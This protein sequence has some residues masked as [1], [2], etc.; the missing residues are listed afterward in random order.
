M[1]CDLLGNCVV[2]DPC[3]K[4][5]R[6]SSCDF[7]CWSLLSVLGSFVVDVSSEAVLIYLAVLLVV[8]VL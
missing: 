5:V 3:G 2:L 4:I 7:G 6:A 8:R 1:A